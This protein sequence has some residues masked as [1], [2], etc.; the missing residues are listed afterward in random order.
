MDSGKRAD[1][2]IIWS[3]L[4][5]N[6]GLAHFNGFSCA[7]KGVS[8]VFQSNPVF[9]HWIIPLT[10]ACLSKC[11]WKYVL[12]LI[13]NYLVLFFVKEVDFR[14]M[15]TCIALLE[16]LGSS[17][18]FP[19][20]ISMMTRDLPFLWLWF[21]EVDYFLVAEL[22]PSGNSYCAQDDH[23]FCS[24]LGWANSIY[25][26]IRTW[27]GWREVWTSDDELWHGCPST[28]NDLCVPSCRNR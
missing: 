8:Q 11:L 1:M 6:C 18:Y 24:L 5:N 22:L 19:F 2:S 26:T 21:F 20:H 28:P 16:Q 13:C 7:S 4:T 12:Y 17:F 3:V 27:N 14:F 10:L 23:C 9:V 15:T 25:R